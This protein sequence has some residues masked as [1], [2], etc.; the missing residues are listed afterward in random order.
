MTTRLHRLASKLSHERVPETCPAVHTAG[1][2]AVAS[3]L[4]WASAN[5]RWFGRM[6]RAERHAFEV[7]VGVLVQDI[8][9]GAKEHG[10][11]LLRAAHVREIEEHLLMNLSPER[12]QAI[13]AGEDVAVEELFPVSQQ[14]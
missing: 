5:T 8:T 7:R 6:S 11:K 13:E 12:L 14:S 3:F 9:D 2:A 1:V 10:T 4:H